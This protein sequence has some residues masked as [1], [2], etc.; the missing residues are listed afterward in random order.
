MVLNGARRGFPWEKGSELDTPRAMGLLDTWCW[1]WP[2]A[3]PVIWVRLTDVASGQIWAVLF[4]PGTWWFDKIQPHDVT[5]S[6]LTI[7]VYRHADDATSPP[8]WAPATGEPVAAGWFFLPVNSLL[9]KC[10]PS[11]DDAFAANRKQT[12][13]LDG[14]FLKWW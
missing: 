6:L 4:Y 7:C 2:T 14:G 5:T 9:V 11:M 3:M 8:F 13:G 10:G 1:K 12:Y